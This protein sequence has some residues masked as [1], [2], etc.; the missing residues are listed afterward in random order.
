MYV[1]SVITSEFNHLF[2]CLLI[3]IQ[4]VGFHIHFSFGL[5]VFFLLILGDFYF[6]LCDNLKLYNHNLI[7]EF[8]ALCQFFSSSKKKS[9]L[10][11]LQL[12][13]WLE[14]IYLARW[15]ISLLQRHPSF[16]QS[17]LPSWPDLKYRIPSFADKLIIFLWSSKRAN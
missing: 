9:R 6:S 4:I 1:K 2:M 11:F 12:F 13:P 8:L 7:L 14:F 10:S 15:H 16:P 3:L 17:V 5:V